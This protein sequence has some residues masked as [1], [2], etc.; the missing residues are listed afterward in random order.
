MKL[1]IIGAGAIGAAFSVPCS[2]NHQTVLLGT[3]LEDD[4]INQLQ[5]GPKHPA[6]DI[7]LPV[8]VKCHP[9]SNHVQII[10]DADILVCAVSS[11]GIP[12]MIDLLIQHYRDNIPMI[13]LSKGL[14]VEDGA[15]MSYSDKI[16]QALNQAGFIPNISVIKGPCLAKELAR[17][18]YT[19]VIVANDDRMVANKLSVLLSTDNFVIQSCH[20][21]IGVELCSSFKHLY[22]MILGSVKGLNNDQGVRHMNTVSSLIC[23]CLLEMVVLVV[24][25]GGEEKTV[26]GLAGLGD[27]FVTTMGGRNAIMGMYL[28]KGYLCHDIQ[29][30]QMSGVTVEGVILAQTIASVIKRDTDINKVPLLFSILDALCDNKQLKLGEIY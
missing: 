11:N 25:Y 6:L 3:H 27:L 18:V 17:G 30:N 9:F 12:W 10:R 4:L 28:G 1:V 14:C 5:M 21:R 24:Q 29:T 22:A 13:V 19:N 8:S 20:D 15:L 7:S 23:R 2:I 26:Y 16:I